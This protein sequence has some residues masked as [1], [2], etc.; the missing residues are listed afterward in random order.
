[1]TQKKKKLFYSHTNVC[2]VKLINYSKIGHILKVIYFILWQVFK[3]IITNT[4]GWK[5]VIKTSKYSSLNKLNG[6]YFIHR[7]TKKSVS[8]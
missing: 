1:M 2:I 6:V 3:F 4:I 5:T 7:G 8:G